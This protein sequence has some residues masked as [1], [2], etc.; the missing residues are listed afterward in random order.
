MPWN[1]STL[2]SERLRLC[3]LAQAGQP[4]AELARQFGVS[5]RTAY[6]W[7]HRY[8]QEGEEGLRDRSRRP[9][10][11][12]AS[13]QEEVIESIRTLKEQYPYWGPRKLHCL[14][15]AQR[16]ERGESVP[17]AST[18]K[19]VL[20]RLGLTS[21]RVVP[22]HEAVGRFERSHP[23]ELWQTDF[24][25]P[26][27]LPD[28][29][30]LWP[31]PVLDDH[32]RFCVS[33][34]VALSPTTEAAIQSVKAG[35]ER[36][37]LPKELLS[38]HG[39]AFGV[40]RSALTAFTVHLWAC[41]IEHRQGRRAH[42]Q[43]QGKLERFNRTLEVEC[44]RRHSYPTSEGWNACLEAYRL[45]YNTLRPHEA[46]E[47]LPPEE[48][49]RPSE[50]PYREPDRSLGEAGEEWEHR[51]V[52][53]SGRIWLLQHHVPVG[54]AFIGWTVSARHDGEGYWTVSFRGHRLTQVYLARA[55]PYK[56][57]PYRSPG[58][59]PGQQPPGEEPA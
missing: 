53:A 59:S 31:V 27:S 2:M 18:V 39:S 57:K 7:L 9:H 1:E 41:G 6:K 20:V 25:A 4:M 23:N 50:C 34:Q 22:Q 42:P 35:M 8:E 5:P 38:D 55:A 19:R 33:L 47:D 45:Q 43:T 17:S 48:R 52:D 13:T 51:R 16:K 49:Y 29:Q 36:Y 12:P 26:F 37:G 28:G 54:Q 11:S 56:P 32:S 40:S 14:L 10:D 24:T 46:L 44:L 58:R 30:K 3:Q 15:K 21:P